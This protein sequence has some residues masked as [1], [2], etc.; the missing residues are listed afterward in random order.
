MTEDLEKEVADK[1][2]GWIKD[3]M[4]RLETARVSNT[5]AAAIVMRSLLYA[6]ISGLMQKGATKAEFL[7]VSGANWDVVAEIRGK[8]QKEKFD[9]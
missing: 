5:K 2:S 7:E 4:V 9:A 3:S 6:L 8:I 1:L